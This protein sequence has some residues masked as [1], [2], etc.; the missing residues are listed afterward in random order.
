MPFSS[1]NVIAT[2]FDVTLPEVRS[3]AQSVEYFIENSGAALAPTLAGAIALATSKQTAI[4]TV[5]VTA[6]I[7]CFIFY[8]GALF[9]IGPEAKALR[10]EMQKRATAD[11]LASAGSSD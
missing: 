3:T 2:V 8:L 7:L 9:F 11:K 6:W 10:E 5:C 1:P 4:I